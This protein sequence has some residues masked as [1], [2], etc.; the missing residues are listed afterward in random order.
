M[1]I[2]Y[3]KDSDFL[4]AMSWIF[5]KLSEQNQESICFIHT[6]EQLLMVYYQVIVLFMTYKA[7]IQ[8]MMSMTT[9]A[10][11]QAQILLRGNDGEW[12]MFKSNHISIKSLPSFSAVKLIQHRLSFR[13]RPIHFPLHS[14][15]ESL[16]VFFKKV[17]M[18]ILIMTLYVV[19]QKKDFVPVALIGH[20]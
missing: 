10:N 4:I 9:W 3:L 11:R 16:L 5:G 15:S 19:G 14:S 1:A 18:E 12:L 20:I 17:R 2:Q 13:P 6:A 7:G 8:M